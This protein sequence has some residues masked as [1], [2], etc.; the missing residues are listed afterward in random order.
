[1]RGEVVESVSAV[2]VSQLTKAYGAVVAVDG[3]DLEVG[4]GEVFGLLGPNGAGKTTLVKALV[5]LAR[6][7]SGF[8]TVFGHPAGSLEAKAVTGYL[9][10][11]FRFHEWMTATEFL[12]FHGKLA[13]IDQASANKTA[14][15]LL[16][17]V[18]LSSRADSRLSTFSKGMLQRIGIA[19]ALVGNPRIAFLDEPTSALD[20]I[21]RRE[22]R[23]L[24]RALRNEGSTV[25]L[26]SH[27]LS[28]VE[29]VCD[30]VAIL[31]AGR[32]V[33]QGNL[34]Q[35][36]GNRV[37]TVR[38]GDFEPGIVRAALEGVEFDV[39]EGRQLVFDID[40][41]KVVPSI[42]R[43]IVETGVDVYHVSIESN[44]L[45]DLFVDMVEATD[46]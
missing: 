12:G 7:D 17:R 3:I 10:E 37:L 32:L 31:S 1:M 30:R 41:E 44:S 29:L 26:N 18:G 39:R 2:A 11:L 24:I 21:G 45:E 36:L 9:P 40:D 42:V 28:E 46:K 22:V 23:D 35:L 14:S 5:G 33:A 27:L 43:A 15:T 19:Q 38:V 25:F 4:A 8:A 13:R 20:P 34:E 16:E 6:A